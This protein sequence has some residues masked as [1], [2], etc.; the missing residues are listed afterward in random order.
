MIK[1]STAVKAVLLILLLALLVAAAFVA[2]IAWQFEHSQPDYAGQESLPGLGSQVNVYRDEH[3]V[4][5]IFAANMNDAVRALGYVHAGERMFQ[6]EMSRRAGQGRLAEAAGSSML[7]IDKF[8]RTLGLYHLAE[9]SFAAMSPEAQKFFQSYADGVNAWID[10]HKDGLPPEFLVLGIKPE[11]WKPADSIVWGKLMGLQLSHNYKLELLRGK[12]AA[13]LSPQQLREMFPIP[14]GE[15]PVTINPR[16]IK[17]AENI[18]PQAPDAAGR[19]GD[20]IGLDHGA[21]NEWV[22]SGAH[23][24]S[25]KPILANDPHL[26][27]EAPILW[28]LVRI[29]T[30]GFTIRGATVPGVPIVLL[31]QNDA[32]AWGFTT[33]GSDVQDLFIETLDPKDEDKYLV[34]KYLDPNG[35]R[36][37]DIRE[38]VIK[39]KHGINVTLRV[40]STRHG[41]VLSDIDEEMQRYAGD[42]KVMAFAFTGLGDR[43]R[44]SESLMWLNRAHNWAE[45]LG[46]LRLY[47]TPPQNVVFA[48]AKGNIGFINPGIVPVRKQ[49]YGTVPA[50]GASGQNDWVGFVPFNL[51]PQLYNPP[52]GYIFNANNAVVGPAFTYF[53][54]QDWEEPYRAERL[55]QFFDSPEKQTLDTSSSMQADHLSM[56]VRSLKPFLLSLEPKDARAKDALSLIRAWD[57]V[58]DR[59]RPEPLIFDAWLYQMR[60]HML[61]DKTDDPLKEKG[62][63]AALSI[64]RI[65]ESQD[66]AWCGKSLAKPAED[67]QGLM[68]EALDDALDMIASRDGSDMS[69]W[70]WGAEHRTF[71]KNKVFGHIPFLKSVSDL[72]IASSGDFY[73]LDR[74]GSFAHAADYPFARTHGGGYRGIYDLGAPDNSR[75]MI[76]TG[77]SGHIFSPHYSDLLPLWN[78]V[79]SIPLSGSEEELAARNLPKL[80]LTPQ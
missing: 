65:L 56:V 45:V 76:A 18:L 33:T 44:T 29:V 63:Y 30:P 21:S 51:L 54:G 42:G 4:P 22:M 16:V 28:Y 52:A 26:G 79:K 69:K 66:Y 62:P 53:I 34:P 49:G 59:D 27:L 80:V 23:T 67:C 68:E 74:G 71:L 46:A 7:D 50:D 70:R 11:P 75:F 72:S 36:V 61:A 77:E 20:L 55:Q 19:L 35:S 9:S 2:R 43:D 32:I 41:P 12:L 48:D 47:E 14:P 3:G 31:G 6:M 78:E 10:T 25:G 13:I 39:V 40:R 73:T 60:Q 5:H 17:K 8:T 64:A 1:T 37:F 15:A 24:Q 38:E 58:M 57:G